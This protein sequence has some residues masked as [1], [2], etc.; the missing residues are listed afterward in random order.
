MLMADLFLKYVKTEKCVNCGFCGSVVRCP[1]SGY[2][3]GCGSCY[4]A[5]PYMAREPVE[6]HEPRRKIK[7]IVDGTVYEVAE[8]TT[9]MRALESLGYRFTRFPE[10]NAIFSPC[11]T[12]GC[13]SCSVIVNGEVKPACHTEVKDGDVIS[14]NVEGVEPLR[15]VEGF[16]PHQVGGVG[17]PYWVKGKAGYIEV[18]AFAAGC[19]LRC[20]TCQN[21]FVTYNSALPA[22]TPNEAAW[23]LSLMRKRYG[24]DRMAISG[25]EATL[26]HDWIV[27]FFKKLRRL[28]PDENARFHLDTNATVL[29]RERIDDLIM[30]GVTDIG[31]DLKAFRLETFQLITGVEDKEL[32][33]KYLKTSWD[34]VKYIAD[35]YYP[36]M[37][38]MGI[39]V[40]YNKFFYPT[41]EELLKMGEKIASIDPDV[42]VCVLDYR[43]E[44]RRREIVQ[45][46][47]KEMLRVKEALNGVGLRK[48]I[49]Q[50]ITGHFGP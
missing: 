48:V 28:N 12:G 35:N 11:L 43:P 14:T 44:F 47:P 40:P 25:G 5:C 30:A 9:V 16:S 45:P 8:K 1:G 41:L 39:G 37:V 42:Q 2:C 29:T 7:I 24:V 34:A 38:F 4:V 13:Y 23:K 46:T 22:M 26:N 21:Y 49:V 50:T 27:K 33:L 19:N 6:D 3:I 36:E 15:I 32:A 31:P 10:E 20:P 17:T 18:A